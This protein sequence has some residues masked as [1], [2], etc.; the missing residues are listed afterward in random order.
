[1]AAA[2][3]AGAV[4]SGRGV[5]LGEA[6][7]EE[8]LE[9][10][11]EADEAWQAANDEQA[12]L[13]AL[14]A[15]DGLGFLADEAEFVEYTDEELQLEAPPPGPEAQ[16]AALLQ[17]AT[18]YN[19]TI[20]T[21]AN[22]SVRGPRVE[23]SRAKS[24]AHERGKAAVSAIAHAE[25]MWRQEAEETERLKQL[26]RELQ[27]SEDELA[28]LVQIGQRDPNV[29]QQRAQAQACQ[30]VGAALA[31][32]QRLQNAADLAELDAAAEASQR[33]VAKEVGS[34]E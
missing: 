29:T 19:G 4:P 5:A 31:A 14:L 16:D 8:A 28:R 7:L 22:K 25:D 3:P 9:A 24:E 13:D 23:L 15:D 10:E 2:L 12:E 33:G 21:F 18:H 27:A 11:A 6:E 26:H 20:S 17:S 34:E 32:Q 30:A 1:M